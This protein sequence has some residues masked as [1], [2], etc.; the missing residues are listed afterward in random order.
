[1]TTTGA[2][3]RTSTAAMV[4]RF[5][6]RW[7]V[8]D[9]DGWVAAAQPGATRVYGFGVSAST[10]AGPGVAARMRELADHGLVVTLQRRAVRPDGCLDYPFDYLV[11]R[12]TRPCP[13]RFPA[14]GPLPV[15]PPPVAVIPPPTIAGTVRLDSYTRVQ[16][17]G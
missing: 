6:A 14:L 3:T 16:P 7:S 11:S 13:K 4:D 8:D 5:R 15:A 1:M 10:A 12:T 9:F 17:W 2:P